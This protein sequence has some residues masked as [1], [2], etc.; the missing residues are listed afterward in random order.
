ME[1]G[2]GDIMHFYLGYGTS[3]VLIQLH[4]ELAGIRLGLGIRRPIITDVFVFAGDLAA[5][6][7]VTDGNI[8]D[9]N[10]FI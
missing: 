4:P 1:A 5:V 6:T 2:H 3:D 8:Y 9:K 7:P 10:F